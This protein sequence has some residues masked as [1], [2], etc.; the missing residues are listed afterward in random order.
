M[1][2]RESKRSIRGRRSK[3]G[4]A[5]EFLITKTAIEYS[6]AMLIMEKVIRQ[7][8]RRERVNC[9]V[10]TAC[11]RGLDVALKWKRGRETRLDLTAY[12]GGVVHVKQSEAIAS[13][14]NQSYHSTNSLF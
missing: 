11:S 1:Q 12:P 9:A 5:S 4:R 2:E 3:E 6:T 7:W 13:L 14:S 8:K 10:N